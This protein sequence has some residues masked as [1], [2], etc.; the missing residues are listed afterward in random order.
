MS[1]EAGSTLQAILGVAAALGAVFAAVAAWRSA[2]AAEAASL[3]ALGTDR[4]SATREP[5]VAAHSIVAEESRVGEIVDEL[6]LQYSTLFAFAGQSTGSSSRA[7]MYQSI[8][9]SKR[10][11]AGTLKD[12]ATRFID[13]AKSLAS[14]SE[15]DLDKALIKFTGHLVR[16]RA[17]REDLERRV[18]SVAH[19]NRLYREERIK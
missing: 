10:T 16:V 18:E 4:R 7:A 9:E 3:R 15:N 2:K 5:V 14:A 12:E 19:E 1:D 11:E 8:A 17:I 6:K 13:E